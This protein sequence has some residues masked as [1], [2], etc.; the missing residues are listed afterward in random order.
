MYQ[1]HTY[2]AIASSTVIVKFL[3]ILFVNVFTLLI[4]GNKAT[5]T[6]FWSLQNLNYLP[7]ILQIVQLI[8]THL[9]NQR[10]SYSGQPIF[11]LRNKKRP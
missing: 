11:H 9:V 10:L 3:N 6:S 8:L 7:Q 5:V 4:V 1:H 2:V